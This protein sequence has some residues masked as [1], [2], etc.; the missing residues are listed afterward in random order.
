MKESEINKLIKDM[1][2][3]FNNGGFIDCLRNG[4]TVSKCKCGKRIGMQ[5]DGGRITRKDALETAMDQMGYSRSQA[6]RA[7][8]NQK[9]ALRN[10]GFRG[11]EMRQAARANMMNSQ[12]PG[13]TPMPPLPTLYDNIDIEIADDPILNND[14]FFTSLDSSIPTVQKIDRFGGNFNSAFA[15]ARRSGL[16]KFY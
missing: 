5:Q 6:R 10:Q 8:Q 2:K 11:A 14:E 3:K 12:T 16:D 7:Y 1:V 15:A 13:A 4:G 9:N